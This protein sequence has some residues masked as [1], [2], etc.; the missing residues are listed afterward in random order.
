MHVYYGLVYINTYNSMPCQ[1]R[2]PGSNNMSVAINTL[3]TSIVVLIPFSNERKWDFLNKQLILAPGK[4]IYKMNL[5][6]SHKSTLNNWGVQSN[7][8][9]D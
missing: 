4:M 3:V 7:T 9:A 1:L 2:G 6:I 5:R 8:G